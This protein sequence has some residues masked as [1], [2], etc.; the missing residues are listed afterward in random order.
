MALPGLIDMG[1]ALGDLGPVGSAE[2]RELAK[3]PKDR[4]LKK[5]GRRPAAEGRPAKKASRKNIQETKPCPTDI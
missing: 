3:C 1:L 4:K 5:K 2:H